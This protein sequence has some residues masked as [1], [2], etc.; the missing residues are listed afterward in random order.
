LVVRH[1]SAL[2]CFLASVENINAGVGIIQSLLQ[3]QSN[4]QF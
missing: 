2:S 4:V 3:G 1:G